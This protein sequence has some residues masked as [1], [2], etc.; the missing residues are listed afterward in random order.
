MKERIMNNFVFKGYIF[1][2]N[3]QT[4]TDHETKLNMFV[5]Q[6]CSLI[7]I[8]EYITHFVLFDIILKIEKINLKIMYRIR[9]SL[10]CLYKHSSSDK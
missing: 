5:H 1:L 8:L 6:L 4:T 7:H 2:F 10:Q 3:I 9:I